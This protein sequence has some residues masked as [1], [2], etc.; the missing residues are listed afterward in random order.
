MQVK[1]MEEDLG[2]VLFDRSKKPLKPTE[3]G[4]KIID[5][6]KHI[7][8]D[9]YSIEELLMEHKN[10]IKGRL[11]LGVIPSVAPYLIPQFVGSFTYKY[12]DVKLEI[13]ELITEDIL[14]QL[15]KGLLDIGIVVTPLSEK[16]IREV[17]LYYERMVALVHR[18]HAYAKWKEISLNKLDL[19][20]IWL[21]SEGNCFRSQIINL[22]SFD[23]EQNSERR[24]NYESGS[25]ETIKSLINH[26]GGWTI[27]PEMAWNS[28]EEAINE[29]LV[30]PFEDPA[31]LR[32]VSLVFSRYQFK[33]RL[34]SLLK[35]DILSSLPKHIL[36]EPVGQVVEWNL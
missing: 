21:M 25:L 12:R 33:Q 3:L 28:S 19:N 36:R 9:A 29:S 11:K 31:P 10:T 16:G 5:Q 24:L 22:C 23:I 35:E 7:L 6:A 34:I 32:E 27:I 4:K 26:E 14:D 30:V 17:P 2:V 18:N 15:R 13:K 20:D 8:R 1:K